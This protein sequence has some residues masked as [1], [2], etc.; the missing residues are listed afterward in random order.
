MST[1]V[2]DEI[3]FDFLEEFEAALQMTRPLLEEFGESAGPKSLEEALAVLQYCQMTAAETGLPAL[4]LMIS[5]STELLIGLQQQADLRTPT[6]QQL[7]GQCLTALDSYRSELTN[8]GQSPVELFAELHD[9]LTP[10]RA[11]LGLPE[12]DWLELWSEFGE[13]PGAERLLLRLMADSSD[14]A[15]DVEE[16][17]ATVE[18]PAAKEVPQLEIACTPKSNAPADVLPPVDVDDIAERLAEEQKNTSPE[19]QEVFREEADDHLAQMYQALATLEG[20]LADAAAFATLRRSAHTLKGAAGAVGLQCVGKLAHRTEDLLDLLHERQ[21]PCESATVR[22]LLS[23]TDAIQNCVLQDVAVAELAQTIARL[24]TELERALAAVGTATAGNEPAPQKPIAE[25]SAVPTQVLA[26]A[27]HEK[28]RQ[29]IERPESEPLDRETTVTTM[30]PAAATGSLRVPLTQVDEVLQL[31]GEL[32]VHRSAFEDRIRHLD[33][34]LSELQGAVARL[35]KVGVELETRYGV[36]A[37]QSSAGDD[38]HVLLSK[39]HGETSQATAEKGLWN[40]F[41]SLEFDRYTDF[42]LLSRS[43]AE[44]TSDVGTVASEIRQTIGEFDSLVTRQT[45]LTRDAQTRLMNVRMVPVSTLGQQLQRIVRTTADLQQ[46]RI[47]LQI[48][49][50]DVELDKAVIEQL[51]EPLLH[52]LRNACDHGIESPEQRAELGKAPTAR[53]TITARHQG[54]NA[55]LQIEDDGRGVDIDAV[56]VKAMEKGLVA[57][58][59][60]LAASSAQVLQ[61]L[62]LPGFTTAQQVSQISGRGLGLDIVRAK[63]EELR[64]EINISTTAGQGTQFSIRLPLTLVMTRALLVEV[65]QQTFAIP[66]PDIEEVVRIRPDQLVTA[67]NSTLVEI[68]EATLTFKELAVHTGLPA[69]GEN[70]ARKATALRPAIIVSHARER[71]CV[72]V[73]RILGAREIVVK[74][75]GTHLG[76]VHGLAGA[77]ISSDGSVIPILDPVHL[78]RHEASRPMTPTAPTRP[79]PQGPLRVMIVD[80]SVSVRRVMTRLIDSAGWTPYP[81]IDGLDALEQLVD[82]PQ[83]PDAFLLDVEMP[84]MNGF[85]LLAWLRSQPM[86]ADTPV[87]M[88]T[89]RAGEKHRHKADELGASGYLIKPYQDDELLGKIRELTQHRRAMH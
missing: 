4:S 7:A 73:D 50:Q 22:L 67:G 6:H 21:K 62:F 57:P 1:A 2:G 12:S 80:D 52:L 14:C 48:I 30:S 11:A 41:D 8:S 33:D 17:I 38:L 75:L 86:F 25:S 39:T 31:L 72:G 49:G 43:L 13:E 19:L 20:N 10:A 45:R 77:T 82:L 68:G 23:V 28:D 51:A 32:V 34:S 27:N 9:A 89:S 42:H 24:Q 3:L 16:V 29:D 81:A 59:V 83:P 71:V 63:I 70:A 88:V 85:E 40:E 55:V 76:R 53:I 26:D 60:A 87:V 65:Q 64:G 35:R 54:R 69:A 47:E 36:D 78:V 61:Y 74:S 79:A 56:R 46:K 44:S 58:D 5:W 15:P 18:T 37:L 66:M 84:R